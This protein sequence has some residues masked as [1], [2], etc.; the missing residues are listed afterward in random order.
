MGFRSLWEA[1]KIDK[2]SDVRKNRAALL[3]LFF[4][5]AALYISEPIQSP[6]LEFYRGLEGFLLDGQGFPV[7]STAMMITLAKQLI[8]QGI[9]LYFILF[10]ALNYLEYT[11]ETSEQA[12]V[13]VGGVFVKIE[14]PESLRAHNTAKIA[15]KYYPYFLLL[16]AALLS[17]QMISVFFLMIPFYVIATMLSMTLLEQIYEERNIFQAMEASTA[18]TKG[19]KF[20]IFVQFFVLSSILSIAENLLLNA[21]AS[22]MWAGSLIRAFLF[23]YLTFA[24][25]RLAGIVYKTSRILHL[26]LGAFKVGRF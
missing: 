11:P 5:A 17:I 14:L 18:L 12:K 15:L 2:V 16:G 7:P 9:A 13:G 8:L 4:I 1:L 3:L 24:I 19:L 23:A 21:F 6:L 25:G 20:Y 10:S 22:N 26:S